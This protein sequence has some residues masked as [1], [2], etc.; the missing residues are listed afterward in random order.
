MNTPHDIPGPDRDSDAALT[1]EERELAAQI[2]R[3][4]PQRGP[5]PALDASILRAARVAVAAPQPAPPSTAARA[6]TARRRARRRWPAVFGV[7]ATLA[8]AF[9]LAWQLRPSEELQIVSVSEIPP[10]GAGAAGGPSADAAAPPEADAQAADAAP[11]IEPAPVAE[12]PAEAHETPQNGDEPGAAAAQAAIIDTPAPPEPAQADAAPDLERVVTAPPIPPAPVAAP[13]PA[14]P[15]PPSPQA[16]ARDAA[17]MPAELSAVPPAMEP[18]EQRAKSR[19]APAQAEAVAPSADASADGNAAASAYGAAVP[20]PPP[21]PRQEAEQKK[22]LDRIEVSGARVVRGFEDQPL[23]DEP[24]ASADSPQVREAWL[25]RVRE[26]V[27]RG[28]RDAARDSLREY[29]RR[30]PEAEIPDDLRQLLP[31]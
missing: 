17:Q 18:L 9:G 30:Y 25:R 14:P 10:T 15:A 24:P 16:S 2:A 29:H 3:A 1:P 20:P 6:A 13:P 27:A 28:E 7:A 4:A 12:Q 11:V 5:S 22:E 26:L 23:D 8:L 31:E 19:R 21:P